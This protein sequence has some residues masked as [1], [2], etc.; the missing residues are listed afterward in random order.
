MR[1][2]TFTTTL[3]IG[4]LCT[5]LLPR[6]NAQCKHATLVADLNETTSMSRTIGNGLL[7]RLIPA[8]DGSGWRIAVS[9]EANE[10]EDWT[11]PVNLPLR[12]GESQYL[13]TGYGETIRE[14][15]RYPREIKFVLSE[16]DFARYSRMADRALAS[17]DPEAAGIYMAQLPK[18]S[19]GS[20]LISAWKYE[21]TPDGERVKSAQ[22]RFAV[23]IPE[24]F[25]G[26]KGLKWSRL[27]C[28]RM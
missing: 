13:A 23:T 28:P 8:N 7:L 18:I 25:S 16:S 4:A 5:V 15:L 1:Q 20:V 24:D 3:L 12:T 9:P 17:S 22:L 10:E 19:V 6:S 2:F 26:A 21:T 27:P 14:K 11:Y